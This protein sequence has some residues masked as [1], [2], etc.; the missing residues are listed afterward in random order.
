MAG[1]DARLL[2][3]WSHGL[4]GQAGRRFSVSMQTAPSNAELAAAL[5]SS[6]RWRS[7]CFWRRAQ[8]PVQFGGRS[9]TC[10]P[11]MILPHLCR[12]EGRH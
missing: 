9:S 2:R 11:R 5:F 8:R 7:R 10:T 6:Q 3:R 4:Q 1:V 12:P